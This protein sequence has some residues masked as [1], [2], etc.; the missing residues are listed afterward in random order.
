MVSEFEATPSR[1]PSQLSSSRRLDRIG[2]EAMSLA[3]AS[4]YPAIDRVAVE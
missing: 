3:V 1:H 4:V 2:G